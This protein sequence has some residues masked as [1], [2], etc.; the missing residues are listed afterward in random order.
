MLGLDHEQL[1]DS[2]SNIVPLVIILLLTLLFVAYNPWGWSN[3]FLI[4]EILG[5]HLVPF[6]VL[7]PVTLLLVT[8]INEASDGHSETA[9]RIQS[10]FVLNDE[11]EDSGQSEDVRKEQP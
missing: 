2:V 7:V 8:L 5:L 9:A 1:S 11:T 10:W 6:L 3:W 4:A